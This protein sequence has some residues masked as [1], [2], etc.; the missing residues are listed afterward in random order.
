MPIPTPVT[1]PEVPIVI[2]PDTP[3]V[4]VPPAVTSLSELD[5]PRQAFSVPVIAATTGSAFTVTIA[6]ALHPVTG[7]E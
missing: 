5:E 4:Q 3:V 6:V 7:S 2:T 1:V